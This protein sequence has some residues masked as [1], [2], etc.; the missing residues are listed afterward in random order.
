[1]KK[2]DSR[3]YFLQ[4]TATCALVIGTLALT[5]DGDAAS[6]VGTAT[7]TVLEAVSVTLSGTR[8]TPESFTGSLSP[9]GPLL[10]FGSTSPPAEGGARADAA[11]LAQMP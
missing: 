9:S 11:R 5:S 7:A 1:M 3:P 10:R 6:A 8:F 2:N 4:Q